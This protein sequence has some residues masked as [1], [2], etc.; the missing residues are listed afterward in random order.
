MIRRAKGISH[1]YWNPL[2][3]PWTFPGML[4]PATD[5][6]RSHNSQR[7]PA[8]SPLIAGQASMLE[9]PDHRS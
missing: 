1:R 7:T 8:V 9:F 3:L 2:N 5:T 4:P 6:Y